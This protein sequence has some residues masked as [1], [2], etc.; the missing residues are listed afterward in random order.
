MLSK[1]FRSSKPKQLTKGRSRRPAVE[2]LESRVVPATTFSYATA[3]GAY[4]QDFDSL[5][6][7]GAITPS[8]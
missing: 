2:L 1:W 5:V 4:T 6:N 8:E 3:G 7:A